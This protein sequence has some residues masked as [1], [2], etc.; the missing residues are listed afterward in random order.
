MFI[1]SFWFCISIYIFILQVNKQ[2]RKT[3]KE[4]QRKREVLFS[5]KL[6]FFVT[7]QDALLLL[8]VAIHLS[9]SNQPVNVALVHIQQT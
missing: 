1:H 8:S 6:S 7:V 5:L 2:S 9:L 4:G 3:K